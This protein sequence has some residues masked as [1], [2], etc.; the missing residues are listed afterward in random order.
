MRWYR[1]SCKIIHSKLLLK[2]TV[3]KKKFFQFDA[4][5]RSKKVGL[6]NKISVLYDI[7]GRGKQNGV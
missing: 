4:N 1:V 7:D 6:T 5:D 3:V 2:I